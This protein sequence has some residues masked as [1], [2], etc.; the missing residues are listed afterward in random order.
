MS[1]FFLLLVIAFLVGTSIYVHENSERTFQAK[2]KNI[3]GLPQGAKVTAL[4][5]KVGEVIKTKPSHDG[6]IV[7]VRITHK[8]F[9]IPEAGSQLTITSFRPNQGRV[10]EIVS[11]SSKLSETKAWIIQEPI[12]TDSW[13]HAS[14]DLLDG[15][16]NFSQTIIKYVTPANFEKVRS[17]FIEASESLNQT[18][19][20]LRKYEESLANAKEKFSSSTHEA[21][22]LLLELTRPI[23][24]L[25]KIITD[26]D[27]TTSLKTELP[28]LTKNLTL[29]S[30]NISKPE[31]TQNIT[32]FKTKVLDSLNQINASLVSYDQMIT[33]P[34]LKKKI[35][36][37]N[38]HVSNLNTFYDNLNKQDLRKLKV[39]ASKAR[40]ITSELEE[41]T[42][43]LIK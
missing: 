35:K 11:P 8:S 17:A 13:L 10:L 33:N 22:L 1:R 4:G 43:E 20:N 24:S 29:I 36:N 38:G 31:F 25:N 37:F 6:I 42:R 7:T 16:K 39:A 30:Q 5:V 18:A 32:N 3:D 23:S 27:I 12:T 9:P 2:F 28:D 15:L 19:N 14:L 34:E 21:N 40:E 41:T 26:K